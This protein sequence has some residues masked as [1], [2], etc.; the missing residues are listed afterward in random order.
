MG[1]QVLVPENSLASSTPKLSQ[2]PGC[3]EASRERQEGDLFCHALSQWFTA[4]ST[5]VLYVQLRLV[6]YTDE[7]VF[8]NSLK[9]DFYL[10]IT[11]DPSAAY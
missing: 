8:S 4:R 6:V 1:T 10:K 7:H 11:P 3:Q 9:G 2:L 5:K